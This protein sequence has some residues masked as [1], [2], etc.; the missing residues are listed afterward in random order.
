MPMAIKIKKADITID[1][2]GS[3]KDLTKQICNKIIP[4]IYQNLGYFDTN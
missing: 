2:S 1:N 4:L 3:I